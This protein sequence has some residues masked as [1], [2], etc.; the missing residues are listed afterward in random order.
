[1]QGTEL[2]QYVKE[3]VTSTKC[4]IWIREEDQCLILRPNRVHHLNET[5]TT[6]LSRLYRGHNVKEV[7]RDISQ[8][9]EVSL[10]TVEEDVTKLLSAVCS[11]LKQ[12]YCPDCTPQITTTPF[13]SH[14]LKYPVLSEIAL[15]YRCQNRCMFCY[16]DAG[17]RNTEELDTTSLR[18]I[19]WKIFHEAHCPSLSFTGGEPTLRN[20]LPELIEYAKSLKERN[21]GMRVN[22]ITN[23]IRCSS[24]NY[25]L[26][27]K[28]AGLDS[29][30][31]S[32]EAGTARIHEA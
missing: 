30:Q 3:I 18:R 29:A 20:D 16:A 27:L 32:L 24:K 26:K 2:E 5:A 7:V 10:E 14:E 21:Q 13:G 12:D 17:Y 4:Y 1:M 6:I 22:L 15:T 23:G 28:Q 19:I 9:F 8:K 11:I 31:V 25:V